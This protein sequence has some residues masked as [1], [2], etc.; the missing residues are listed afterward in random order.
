VLYGENDPSC[1]PEV[2]DFLAK[3]IPGAKLACIAGDD[4]MMARDMPAEVAA[5]I[6]DHLVG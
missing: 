3:Q 4:H 2:A 5:K 1:T 6:R